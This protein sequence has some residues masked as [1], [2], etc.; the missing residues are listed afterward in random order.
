MN[1][2]QRIIISIGILFISLILVIYFPFGFKE[3]DFIVA[4]FIDLILFYKLWGDKK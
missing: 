1:N 3:W 4:V 2:V